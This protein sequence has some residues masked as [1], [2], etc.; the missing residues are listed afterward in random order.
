MLRLM[1][2][3]NKLIFSLSLILFLNFTSCDNNI[4]VL[5]ENGFLFTS[6]KVDWVY[7]QDEIILFSINYKTNDIIW[8][9]SIDGYLGTGNHL[10]S[11][12]EPGLHTITASTG[13]IKKSTWVNVNF[14][15]SSEIRNIVTGTP[16]FVKLRPETYY[17]YIVSFESGLLND[18]ILSVNAETSNYS[19]YKM[20][21]IVPLRDVRIEFNDNIITEN[22]IRMRAISDGSFF[23]EST[24][25]NGTPPRFMNFTLFGE[26]DT[27]SVWVDYN[28]TVDNSAIFDLISEINHILPDVQQIWGS[29]TDINNDGKITILVT[30]VINQENRACGFFNPYDFF[31]R[32]L[33]SSSWNFNPYSNEMDIVYLGM[34]S[35]TLADSYYYKRI[36]AT[37]AHELTHVITFS[38]KTWGKTDIGNLS[39]K[40]EILSIDE[41]LSH[42]S[43]CLI[44][45]SISGDNS[46][47]INHFLERTGDY[48][49]FDRN[50][51]GFY[52]SVG[53]RG[54][55]LLFLSWLFW[56]KGGIDWDSDGNI[57][58]LGGIRFLRALIESDATG[59]DNISKVFGEPVEY[60]FQRLLA[61]I[62]TQRKQG[63]KYRYFLHPRT[64]EPIDLFTNMDYYNHITDK[65]EKII[66]PVSYNTINY[67]RHSLVSW[68]F[69]FFDPIEIK[70][71]D[72][73]ILTARN[74]AGKV[75]LNFGLR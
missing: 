48:S 23:V 28:N 70:Q 8:E 42:L 46:Q 54:S 10:Y 57:I 39:D 12:L 47:F 59:Q 16:F 25:Q 66:I 53:M 71:E 6:P 26:T 31:P 55:M 75:F 34:P 13:E 1:C 32:E 74:H 21:E 38:K 18:F 51:A 37:F 50:A 2:I 49:L 56:E 22:I 24:L 58:D 35:K 73:I 62:N 69:A 67:I 41:G 44:G 65:N 61:K 64:R 33:D 11:Y 7:Y 4:I 36:A 43:E 60:L 45:Y 27:Y 15:D 19:A 14:R 3:K 29:W 52:D 9:S 5:V 72:Q 30:D 63:I 40:R 20:S 17:P 68:S